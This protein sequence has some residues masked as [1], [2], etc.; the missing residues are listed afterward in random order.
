MRIRSLVLMA[1]LGLCGVEFGDARAAQGKPKAS[2]PKK[3][4]TH[5][6]KAV[7]AGRRRP[8]PRAISIS[9]RPATEREKRLI[10]MV[11]RKLRVQGKTYDR[12]AALDVDEA[13]ALADAAV[14]ALAESRKRQRDVTGAQSF[15]REHLGVL[16]E[17]Q[18]EREELERV[19]GLGLERDEVETRS[20]ATR[21]A[22]LEPLLYALR[23]G[24]LLLDQ[25]KAA[26]Q[27][28]SN[29]EE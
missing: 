7:R 10:T 8:D 18:V 11:L 1:L 22:G 15:L 20:E 28:A 24:T 14:E 6:T 19:Q 23:M 27:L 9:T 3:R 29:N 26:E 12:D 4:K 16:L 17:N 25:P 13:E 5:E 2:T 21:F